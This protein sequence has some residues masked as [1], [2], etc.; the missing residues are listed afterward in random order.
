VLGPDARDQA[1]DLAEAEGAAFDAL[2]KQ[3]GIDVFPKAVEMVEALKQRGLKT[4]LATSSG[5]DQLGVVRELTGVDFEQLTDAQTTADDAEHAKPAPDLI[6][7][8]AEAGGFHPAQCLLIGD[9]PHD[10]TAA[11]RAGVTTLAVRSGGFDAA[12]LRAAGARH[13]YDDA[14][15]LLTHLGDALDHADPKTIDLDA[16]RLEEFMAGAIAVAREAVDDGGVPIG[17]TLHH[18]D[19][20]LIVRGFN[21]Q[22]RTA[23]LIDHAEVVAFKEAAGEVKQGARG[24]ILACTLEPC[25]MCLGASMIA[26]VDTIIFGHPAPA[27]AGSGR[28]LPPSEA[29]GV[30]PRLLGGI[31]HADCRQLFEEWQREHPGDGPQQQYVDH[32]LKITDDA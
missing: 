22:H 24:L 1:A 8:A 31:R 15:D 28:M 26:G 14:A 5:G 16:A 29:G 32:L 2:A 13:V 17:C 9:S 30:M 21:R 7:A 3:R 11:R 19:G 6:L 12:A 20:E 18:P 27:D 10:A 4:V 25:V 23:G